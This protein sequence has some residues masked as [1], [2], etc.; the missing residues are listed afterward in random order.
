VSLRLTGPSLLQVALK[1]VDKD[2][3]QSDLDDML[4]KAGLSEDGTLVNYIELAKCVYE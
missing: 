2:I 4:Q 1:Y 3:S